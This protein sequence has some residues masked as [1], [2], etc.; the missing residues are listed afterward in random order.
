MW[1]SHHK[2]KEEAV[3]K[4][5]KQKDLG[6]KNKKQRD[7]TERRQNWDSTERRQNWEQHSITP[8]EWLT[9]LKFLT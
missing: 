7:S 8:S 4:E 2:L 6:K 3:A 1:H 5:E 9:R